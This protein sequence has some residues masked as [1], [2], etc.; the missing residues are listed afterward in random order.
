MIDDLTLNV[1]DDRVHATR[2]EWLSAAVAELRPAFDA[3]G[4]SLAN[5]I[6]VACGFPSTA[7]R[8]G[9]VGEVWADTASRDK[10]I[11]ILISPVLDSPIEV[12]QTLIAQLCHATPGGL[13]TG[14]TYRAAAEKL[15][16]EPLRADWKS[17]R[18][19]QDF[20]ETY[21][22]LLA[23]LGLYPHAALTVTTK[24][25]QATR[26]LKAVCDCGYTIRLTQKWADRGLPTC[27]CGNPFNLA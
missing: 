3:A 15:G 1:T 19:N 12:L 18:G 16:L 11:E 13:N 14:A 6:R 20:A 2:E 7:V 24:P 8:S 25:K 4:V 23:G 27:V 10:T 26:M 21:A 9:T 5:N 17:V 22:P